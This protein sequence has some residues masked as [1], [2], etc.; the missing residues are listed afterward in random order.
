MNAARAEGNPF[1][2]TNEICLNQGLKLNL[3]SE[4]ALLKPQNLLV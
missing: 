3:F 4:V 1:A 2:L